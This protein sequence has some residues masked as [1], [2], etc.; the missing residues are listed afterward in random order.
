MRALGGE[1]NEATWDASHGNLCRINPTGLSY[2]SHGNQSVVTLRRPPPPRYSLTEEN[3]PPPPYTFARSQQEPRNE[4]DYCLPPPY[5]VRPLPN[6]F[7][8][9]LERS[10]GKRK[11]G[12]L[13]VRGLVAVGNFLL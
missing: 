1:A 8:D 5:T 7:C 4:G 3:R 6:T 2:R 11:L 12:K 9:S 10:R 13:L